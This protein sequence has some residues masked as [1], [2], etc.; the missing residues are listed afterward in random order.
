MKIF[1][2]FRKNLVQKYYMGQQAKK[3]E[4]GR[5]K[6]Q[7]WKFEEDVFV[8][9]FKAICTNTDNMVVADIPVGTNRFYQYL[10]SSSNVQIVYGIDLSQDMLLESKKKPTK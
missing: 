10:D 3:Y 1:E 5:K 8:E 4:Q 9:F 2:I 6:N 7:K